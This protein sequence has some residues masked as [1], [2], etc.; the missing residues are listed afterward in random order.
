MD[1][2]TYGKLQETLYHER[3][4][5]GLEVYIL[6][7]PGFQQTFATF[8]T[9]YGS[10]DNHFVLPTTGEEVQVPDGIAHFLEHKMFEEE[11]HD[12][13]QDFAAHGASAN[14]FTSFDITTYLFSSTSD[15]PENLTTLID[16]VQRPYFTD[17]NVEKEKGI[18]GQEIKMYEDNPDWRCYFGILQGLYQKHPV[19]I[20][21]AGTVESIA[22]ISKELLYTCYN[23][24]YHP[25]NMLVF[26]VG[27]VD[28]EAAMQLIRENQ[29]QKTY[30]EQP[31]IKRIYPK[32][33]AQAA[34]ERL[35]NKLPV[36]IPRCIFGFKEAS[37]GLRG[38]E[39]LTRELA[40][41]LVMDAIFGKSSSLFQE[42]LNDGLIDQH[43][44]WEYEI[45][46]TYGHSIIGGNSKDP[47]RLMQRVQEA[48]RTY[49]EQG[50]PKEELE[51][52]RRKTIGR[53]M[54]GLDSPRYIS[55]N[56]TSYRFR[57][58]DFFDTLDIL[59]TVTYEACMQHMKEHVDFGRW[60]SSIV[61]PTDQAE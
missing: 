11:D 24:F 51:R 3:L 45:A 59:Q 27:N 16:F 26:I 29:Q 56:F 20:D 30:K 61:W 54:A 38:N 42:L 4:E 52:C 10:I 40:I 55:R 35:E 14:A 32:E 31:E 46:P 22:K 8:S 53:F 37:M 48:L 19:H 9:K 57:D 44:S 15:L 12:V 34:K 47:D 17:E 13:F 1:S 36:S 43:F 39:L 6:P 23:T 25:S 50:V 2:K 7:K 21:I 58:V 5:N 18:I 28:P 60:S 33:P 41:G 49:L